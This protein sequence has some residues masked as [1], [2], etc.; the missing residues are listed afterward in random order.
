MFSLTSAQVT[1]ASASKPAVP[2]APRTM[3]IS[4]PHS[5][6]VRTPHVC[7]AAAHRTARAIWPSGDSRRCA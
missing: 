5:G 1:V 3:S 4:L 7:I 6:S 2:V